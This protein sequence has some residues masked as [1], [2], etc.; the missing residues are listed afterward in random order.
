MS[1]TLPNDIAR[2]AQENCLL[3]TNCLRHLALKDGTGE[4]VVMTQFPPVTKTDQGCN[5]QIPLTK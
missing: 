1:N 3:K 2:C 4:R 5:Y